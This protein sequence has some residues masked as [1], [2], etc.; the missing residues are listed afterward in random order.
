MEV[1]RS[2][3]VFER[4]TGEFTEAIQLNIKF[5]DLK[6]IFNPLGGDHNLVL[7]YRIKKKHAR[8]MNIFQ[9]LRFDFNNYF[10]E[11]FPHVDY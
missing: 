7:V 10:Y 8:K 11:L 6:R 2:I 4:K 5:E 9:E 3:N 1:K